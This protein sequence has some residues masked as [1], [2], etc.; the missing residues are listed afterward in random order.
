MYILS[1]S[2]STV[3]SRIFFSAAANCCP[4]A[5]TQHSVLELADLFQRALTLRFPIHR[6]RRSPDIVGARKGVR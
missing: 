1:C 6:K 3:K 4:S 2:F 5:S